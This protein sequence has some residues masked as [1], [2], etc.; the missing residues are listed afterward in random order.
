M[1]FTRI[2]TLMLFFFAASAPLAHAQEDAP[3]INTLEEQ[4][5]SLKENSNT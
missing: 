4:F 2:F 5:R 1:N 3:P